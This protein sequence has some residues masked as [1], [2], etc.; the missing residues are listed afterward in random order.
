MARGAR[1]RLGPARA[2]HRRPA[3]ARPGAGRRR[4]AARRCAGNGELARSADLVV[5]CHKP[6]PARGGRRAGRRRGAG[7]RLDPRRRAARGRRRP[8]TPAARSYRVLPS[9]PVEVRQGVVAAGP[10][11]SRRPLDAEVVELFGELGA[12]RRAST[13]SL[14][15]VGDGADEH[16]R[17]PTARWSPRPRSTP[18]CATACPPSARR[19]LV[20]QTM[21]GTAALLRAPRLRHARR[22]PRGHLAGRLHRPRPRRAGAG[23]RARRLL[24]R[25]GRRAPAGSW[26]DE[27]CSSSPTRATRSRTT[28]A[29]LVSVYVILII[30]YILSSL[31]FA[32]RRPRALL[33]LVERDPRASCATSS[34]PYLRDLPALHPAA[35]PARPQPDRRDLRAADRRRHRRPAHPRVSD[36][37]GAGVGARRRSSRAPS[38]VAD[39]V[40]KALVRADVGAGRARREPPRLSTS[41]TCATTAWPSARWPAGGT[42]VARRRGGGARRRCWPTSPSTPAGRWSGCRPAC[43]S[44]ARSATSIDRVRLGAVTDFLKLPSWPAFNL[45]DT[46]ITVGVVA[47]R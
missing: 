47:A 34:E 40:T 16:A 15:D 41:S 33:A 18:A 22:A 27:R 10:L 5:L 8:P 42:I 14:L 19:E 7:G 4:P 1:P 30:A 24:R 2:V 38:L 44:A 20:V 23:G 36:A 37:A 31:F 25:A 13:R 21:A 28:S 45:A 46:A 11:P 26:A 29:P 9:T 39:Q 32:L 3:R 35:R 12:A 17:P 6:A 43:C